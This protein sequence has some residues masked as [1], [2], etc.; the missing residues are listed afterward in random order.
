MRKLDFTTYFSTNIGENAK[1]IFFLENVPRQAKKWPRIRQWQI[2]TYMRKLI[3]FREPRGLIQMYVIAAVLG[4]NYCFS[5]Y[6]N[7]S[8]IG[9]E[10][11]VYRQITKQE[12]VE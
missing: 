9:S 10:L 1:I 12:I 5:S 6:L 11:W 8:K 7:A 3:T 4:Q 2:V